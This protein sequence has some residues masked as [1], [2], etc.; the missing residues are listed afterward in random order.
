LAFFEGERERG[1]L[2][3]S[4]GLPSPNLTSVLARA[5]GG[6][7]IGTR[8]VGLVARQDGRFVAI[9]RREGLGT[10]SVVGLVRDGHGQVWITTVGDGI[11]RVCEDALEAVA[12]G[13]RPTVRA[14]V[15]TA[16]DGLPANGAP[17][18]SPPVGTVDTRG[19]LWLAL[20]RG[21]LVFPDPTA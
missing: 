21:A 13:R 12:S 18:R 14:T 19:Q 6:L 8:D 7:W 3:T 10:D 11:V 5:D 16:R 2:G 1:R 9:A 4:E 17:S 15:L 20:Y